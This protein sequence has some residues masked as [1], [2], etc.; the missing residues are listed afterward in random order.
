MKKTFHKYMLACVLAFGITFISGAQF[1]ERSVHASAGNSMTSNGNKFNFTI[2][3]PLTKYFNTPGVKVTQGFQQGLMQS[4]NNDLVID[5]NSNSGGSL[6]CL[7]QYVEEPPVVLSSCGNYDMVFSQINN[8]GT[9]CN[10]SFTIAWEIWDECGNTA[11]WDQI[12]YVEDTTAPAPIT[13]IPSVQYFNCSDPEIEMNPIFQDNCIWNSVTIDFNFNNI[14][15]GCGIHHTFTWVVSDPCGNAATYTAEVHYLDTEAPSLETSSNPEP[16]LECGDPLPIAPFFIDNCA[17]SDL[18]TVEVETINNDQFSTTRNFTVTDPCG[19]VFTYSEIFYFNC[20]TAPFIVSEQSDIEGQCGIPLTPETPVFGDDNDNDLQITYSVNSQPSNCGYIETHTW[21]ATN[22]CGETATSHIAVNYLDTQTP[23]VN[24]NEPIEIYVSCDDNTP[25][26]PNFQDNCDAELDVTIQ[27]EIVFQGV[28]QR[29]WVAYDDCGFGATFT[30]H[31]HA[32]CCPTPIVVDQPSDFMVECGDNYTVTAPDFTDVNGDNLEITSV[33]STSA[34]ECGVLETH[35]FTATNSCGGSVSV[36]VLIYITD[37]QDPYVLPGQQNDY[38]VECGGTMPAAPQ[39]G[40]ACDTNLDVIILSE[41]NVDNVIIREWKATDDCGHFTTF[42]QT[43]T[44]T[45]CES[46]VVVDQPADLMVECGDPF[47]V[48]APS[49]EDPNGDNLEITSAV[50]TSPIDCGLLETH[51]YTATNSCGLN[52]IATALVYITDTQEPYAVGNQQTEY[53]VECGDVMPAAPE[54]GD[55]CDSS[56]EVVIESETNNNNTITRVW[57]ATDDCGFTATFTQTISIS[58]CETPIVVDQPQDI[59]VECGDGYV[60]IPPSFEDI[61]GGELTITNSVSSAQIECGV[62][63]T[64]TYTATNNCGLSVSASV[65]VIITDTQAPFVIEGQQ[66]EYFLQCTDDLP[67]TPL[68]GDACD[69][70]LTVEITSDLSVN[71]TIVRVWTATDDCGHSASFTQVIHISCCEA[72][73]VESTPETQNMECGETFEVPAPV[74]SDE[75]DSDLSIDHSIIHQPLDCGYVETHTW[76]ATNDCGM[77]ATASVDVVVVD[78]TQPYFDAFLANVNISC[79]D[80]IP[81]P[82]ELTALD[83]CDTDVMVTWEME[84]IYEDDCGNITWQINYDA[85]DNC[86]NIATTSYLIIKEDKEA[87]ILSTCPENLEL[88]C[89]AKLPEAEEIKATDACDS[90]VEVIF[91]EFMLD[92]PYGEGVVSQCNLLTPVRPLNNPCGYPVNWALSMFGLPKAHR[93]YYI[94]EGTFS[95]MED[96][97][98]NIQ[99]ELHNA[100]NPDNGWNVNFSFSAGMTWAQWIS[101]ATPHSFKADCGGVGANHFDWLYH[102]ML[103]TPGVEMVGFG[104]Y[105]QSTLSTTHAP[106]NGYFGFQWGNGANNY[107]AVDNGFGGW[108]KY[109]GQFFVNGIPYGTNNGNISG[110]GDLALELNCCESSVV[111]RQWTA[112]DCSGNSVTC[113]QE[114]N[115]G[116]AST[117]QHA[118]NTY[119]RNAVL[120][121]DMTSGTMNVQIDPNPSSGVVR[122]KFNTI[123]NANTQVKLFSTTGDLVAI[124]MD[125]QSEEN[126][127]FVID[128]DTSTLA[129]GVYFCKVTNG[130]TTHTDRLIVTH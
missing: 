100:L 44:A 81:A 103:N 2:G 128:F 22:D 50:T 7:Y 92:N 109:S 84:T 104:G 51:T 72:P 111:I 15:D 14:V 74:F 107:N 86:G 26:P 60:V 130:T 78:N 21:I 56:L 80:E 85:I 33:V 41:T 29:T 105:S 20:C 24:Q 63:E 28:L 69:A 49:F 66:S 67:T 68:F 30:Q 45:C 91:E 115:I 106:A 43:I 82:L 61:N 126:I 75:S 127:D 124:L 1:I 58:C 42:T 98:I 17:S 89:G 122:L 121:A 94:S 71:N 62:E 70:D 47:T 19:N 54:F 46:P 32:E 8:Q 55:A 77:S 10:G 101:Q 108:F 76:T 112:T 9:D 113:V 97:T 57:K 79:T 99:A 64:H 116:G 117:T 90:E 3:E 125:N 27:Q 18:L 37:S 4:L 59:L 36:P 5:P 31:I 102:L 114:I 110:A 16:Y 93:Y 88:E 95:L 129:N 123:E 6:E 73:I 12:Y 38:I 48:I 119:D 87:P 52:A 25:T 34:I 39:F 11:T 40:D 120:H 96:G 53:L 13:P 65:I 118:Q 35:T 83:N 23:F